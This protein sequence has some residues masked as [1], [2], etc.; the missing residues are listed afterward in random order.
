VAFAGLIAMFVTG[1]GPAERFLTFAYLLPIGA[2]LGLAWIWSSVGSRSKVLAAAAVAVLGAAMVAGSV[3]TWAQQHPFSDDED[4]GFVRTVVRSSSGGK[5]GSPVVIGV[6][7][8]GD[9]AGFEAARSGNL[10]R[11]AI[12]ANRIRD[13]VVYIGDAKGLARVEPATGGDAANEALSRLTVKQLKAAG[14]EPVS[15]GEREDLEKLFAPAN[16][17]QPESAAGSEAAASPWSFVWAGVLVLVL[18]TVVGF[19]WSAAATGGTSADA[20]VLAP[21][22]GAAALILLGV[23]ADRAGL[24]LTGAIPAVVSIVAGLAGYLFLTR[25]RWIPGKLRPRRKPAPQI[26]SYR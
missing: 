14:V 16:G 19:G 18:L 23:V 1:R 22:F 6:D 11:A 9:G 2:A 4:A 17:A 15:K 7:A 26:V 5:P 25:D 12:S 20:L 21:A 3:F 8:E 10:V 24:R 13:V